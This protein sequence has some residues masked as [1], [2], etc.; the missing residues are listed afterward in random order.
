MPNRYKE[1]AV[2]LLAEDDP[3]D[4]VM[5]REAFE[6]ALPSVRVHVV[7]DGEQ[8]ID[9]VRRPSAGI[10][11]PD[12]ILLD[13]NLPLRSGLEVLADMKGDDDYSAIPIAVLTASRDP[14]TVQRCYS[15]HANAYIVKPADFDDFAS[16][17]Y[18]IVTWFLGLITLPGHS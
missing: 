6:Q 17:I 7:G 1:D 18:Q 10:H 5:I 14:H 12:L 8:A 9:F 3:G 16:V 4:A 11:R 15:L 13:L 2:I